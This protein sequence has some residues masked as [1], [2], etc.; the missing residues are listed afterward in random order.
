MGQIILAEDQ[1]TYVNPLKMIYKSLKC[2]ENLIIFYA[3]QYFVSDQGW[4]DPSPLFGKYRENL[5]FFF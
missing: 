5:E 3:P 4:A 2:R 1:K